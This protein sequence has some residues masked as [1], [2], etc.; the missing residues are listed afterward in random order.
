MNLG[1]HADK[2]A[3]CKGGPFGHYRVVCG[4]PPPQDV[5]RAAWDR[6]V[7]KLFCQ[8]TVE[9]FREAAA[10]NR[11]SGSKDR[12]NYCFQPNGGRDGD[13]LYGCNVNN[14]C[15]A[16]VSQATARKRMLVNAKFAEEPTADIVVT[17]NA[18]REQVADE[19]KSK[20]TAKVAARWQ[21]AQRFGSSWASTGPPA[22]GPVGSLPS[23]RKKARPTAPAQPS[24]DADTDAE[25]KRADAMS[26]DA[27][28]ELLV[29]AAGN[30]ATKPKRLTQLTLFGEPAPVLPP[31]PA[32]AKAKLTPPAPPRAGTDF[33]AAFR[34]PRAED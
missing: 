27:D 14:I 19:T 33:F 34:S 25:I 2:T 9:T 26:M 13:V 12:V 10:R 24:E 28:D 11:A 32:A 21:Q 18:V 22:A 4:V 30:S 15:T 16:H 7:Y 3:V 29:R 1:F 6:Q 23:I 5:D 8:K 20:I 31:K 17:M